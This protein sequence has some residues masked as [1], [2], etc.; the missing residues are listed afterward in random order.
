ML[1]QH[2]DRILALR[3]RGR[4]MSV[5]LLRGLAIA[6][7][8]LVNNPGSWSYVYPPLAHAGWHG[9]TPTDVVF[10]LFLFVVGF[11]LVLSN[12]QCARFPPVGW[13]QWSRALKLF[14]LGLFLAVF[15]Y[16][17]RDSSYS[18]LEDQ[19]ERIRWLGVLQRIA[20][21]YLITCYLMRYCSERALLTVS[22]LLLAVPWALMLFAPYQD[23]AGQVFHGRLEFGNNFSAWLDQLLLGADHVYYRSAEPFAFDPEGILTTLPAIVSCLLGVFAARQWCRAG[24]SDG[25]QRALCRWWLVAGI[26]LFAAG[27]LAHPWV[28]V[29]KALWS[30]SFVCLSGGVSLVLLAAF[31]YVAD[32]QRRRRA[33]APLLVFGV[34]AIALYMLAGMVG[35]LLIMIPV[36][37]S[38][39]KGWLFDSVYLPL[40]GG[41]VGSLA[42][43]LTCVLVFYWVMWQMYRRRIIWK[44]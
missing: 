3:P 2:V 30:P 14:G 5:D 16:N 8:V 32:V 40:F 18:W 24:D 34:N 23:S 13:P 33:L 11:S 19:I 28:P 38:S 35:R 10:P 41:P 15:S 26:V 7:M 44:V 21:V 39:L 6:A 9:W 17:F 12:H 42:F 4:L 20:L 43:A 27:Q 1:R 29:N 31:Y 25:E 36:G 37:D 22:V